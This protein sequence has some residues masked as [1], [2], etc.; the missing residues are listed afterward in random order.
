MCLQTIDVSFT[1]ARRDTTV[2]NLT[3]RNAVPLNLYLIYMYKLKII[4]FLP[5]YHA[6]RGLDYLHYSPHYQDKDVVIFQQETLYHPP[7]LLHKQ[8]NGNYLINSNKK[9]RNFIFIIYMFVYLMN[10]HIDHPYQNYR[11]NCL[12]QTKDYH[13]LN[14]LYV[15]GFD[16]LRFAMIVSPSTEADLDWE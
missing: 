14:A 12:L 13:N 11:L 9:Y 16:S 10:Y 1:K 6:S 3:N 2:L 4:I 15:H 5:V 7:A 8:T